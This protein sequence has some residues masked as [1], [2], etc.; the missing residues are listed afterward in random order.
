MVTGPRQRQARLD[1][2]PLRQGLSPSHARSIQR[3]ANANSDDL[4][5]ECKAEL[6]PC[7]AHNRCGE[8]NAPTAALVRRG[9]YDVFGDARGVP[10]VESAREGHLRRCEAPWAFLM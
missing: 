3:A 8:R 1:Q 9:R 5:A 7:S 2:L 6:A 4:A 10:V